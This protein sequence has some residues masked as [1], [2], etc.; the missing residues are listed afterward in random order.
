MARRSAVAPE[1]ACGSD[2]DGQRM[3]EPRYPSFIARWWLL[4]PMIAGAVIWWLLWLGQARRLW[5]WLF[6]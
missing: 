6:S 3:S 4:I 1:P 5:S 2:V